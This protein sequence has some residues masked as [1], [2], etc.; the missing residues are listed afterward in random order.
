M[1]DMYRKQA[2]GQ[3]N[4]SD[5]KQSLSSSSSPP[6]S[7]SMGMMQMPGRRGRSKFPLDLV[8]GGVSD[9]ATYEATVLGELAVISIN[10]QDVSLVVSLRVCFLSCVPFFCC[11]RLQYPSRQRN[12]SIS[13]PCKGKY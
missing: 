7:S 11:S 10:E 9:P 1:M 12:G 13:I 5:P 3:A 8:P 4:S 6:G 2:E